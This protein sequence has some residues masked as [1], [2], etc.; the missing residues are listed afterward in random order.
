MKGSVYFSFIYK[1]VEYVS[2]SWP[3]SDFAEMQAEAQA[4]MAALGILTVD[5]HGYMDMEVH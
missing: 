5:V 2:K 1:G 4:L 3:V